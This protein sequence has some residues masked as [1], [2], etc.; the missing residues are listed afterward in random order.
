MFEALEIFLFH[1]RGHSA[2]EPACQPLLL[3]FNFRFPLHTA[4]IKEVSPWTVERVACFL[5]E[6][7]GSRPQLRP[8]NQLWYGTQMLGIWLR[9]IIIL[10]RSFHNVSLSSSNNQM[11]SILPPFHKGAQELRMVSQLEAEQDFN[12][13]L[14]K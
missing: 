5:A 10:S 13:G 3:Q 7:G 2:L 6:A 8:N 1:Q 12:S 9:Y 11:R 4:G 14:C